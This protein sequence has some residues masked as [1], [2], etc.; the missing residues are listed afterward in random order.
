MR[1]VTALAVPLITVLAFGIDLL[2]KLA[3]RE[4]RPCQTLRVPTLGPCPAPGDWS[5]PSNH[6]ALAAAAAVALLFVSRRLGGVALAVWVVR[7]PDHLLPADVSLHHWSVEH[8]PSFAAALARAITD[9]GM[10]GALLLC[11]GAGQTLRYAAMTV[12]ARPRPAAGD[13]ATR[14]TGWLVPARPAGS[15]AVRLP[16]AAGTRRRRGR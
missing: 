16:G 7:A 1:L 10:T 12:I 8:R 9:T 15:G 11:L 5:F 2:L 4:D 3:V 13:W 6:A 14:A